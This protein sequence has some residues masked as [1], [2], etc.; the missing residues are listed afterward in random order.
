M[1]WQRT[2][3]NQTT[4]W[5]SVTHLKTSST[6]CSGQQWPV[7]FAETQ[8]RVRVAHFCFDASA[9]PRLYPFIMTYWL[10]RTS[11][12]CFCYLLC[13]TRWFFVALRGKRRLWAAARLHGGRRS[14]H[15]CKLLLLTHLTWHLQST[16]FREAFSWSAKEFWHHV[17]LF[18]P[19]CATAS[20]LR[21]GKSPST[22][23]TKNTRGE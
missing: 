2:T 4:I 22:L 19:V 6:C 21:R 8:T 17:A 5:R 16:P 13:V 12:T 1:K 10:G 18:W 7:R 9:V 14:K 3:D 11:S 20:L 15:K 23:D